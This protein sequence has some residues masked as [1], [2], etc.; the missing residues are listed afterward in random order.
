MRAWMY[1]AVV[2]VTTLLG[3]FDASYVLFG[4]VAVVLIGILIIASR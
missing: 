1:A 3:A 2:T 4:I